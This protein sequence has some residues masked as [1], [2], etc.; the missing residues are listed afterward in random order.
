[1]GGP[2]PNE[3]GGNYLN[4]LIYLQRMYNAGAKG[5]FDIMSA[6]GYG[7][8]SGPTDHR[9]N[10]I[11]FN[12]ARNLFVRDLMVRNGDE[13]KPIWISEMNWNTVPEGM[14]APFGRVTEEQQARYMPLAYQRA[15]A[16][17]PWLGVGNFWYF[18]DADD[19]EKDQ[20]KYYFRMA[21]PD[22]TL[23]PV[24]YSMKDYAHQTPVMYPGQYDATHWAV[25]WSSGWVPYRK[26]DSSGFGKVA[27]R[28]DSK[29]T[30]HVT[31]DGTDFELVAQGSSDGGRL[32]IRIDGATKALSFQLAPGQSNLSVAHNLPTGRHTADI[33][34]DFTSGI[35]GFTVR[36]NPDGT[37]LLTVALALTLGGAWL[38][39]R[40]TAPASPA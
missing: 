31:F 10:P 26:A 32:D 29:A 35:S 38:F 21:D 6:Q 24:Y 22:F 27:G 16:E 9:M 2:N 25:Q 11:T 40:R 3:L 15:Q 13:H 4:D 19:H 20:P 23:K 30:A 12:Y 17:W 14:E 18:K 1:L 8:W 28:S 34:A 36:T 7:L 37:W 33:T 5:C 39:L